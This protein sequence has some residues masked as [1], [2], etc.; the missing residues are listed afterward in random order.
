MDTATMVRLLSPLPCAT[1]AGIG[2][3]CGRDAFMAYAYPAEAAGIDEGFPGHWV[4]LPVC[5]RCAQDM[6]ALYDDE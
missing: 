1:G 3:Q 4:L 2:R 5:Q 6:A